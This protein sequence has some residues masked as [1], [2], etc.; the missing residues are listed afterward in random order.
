MITNEQHTENVFDQARVRHILAKSLADNKGYIRLLKPHIEKRIADL[1]DAVLTR[2]MDTQD[3]ESLRVRRLEMVDL[4][5]YLD[6]VM[7][8]ADSQL[9]NA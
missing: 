9:R 6:L 1:S 4:L 8:E 7:K 3:R 2:S 5:G